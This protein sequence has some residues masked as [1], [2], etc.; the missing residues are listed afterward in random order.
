MRRLAA[1]LVLLVGALGA[2]GDEQPAEPAPPPEVQTR[3]KP[4]FCPKERFDRVRRPDGLYDVERVPRGTFDARDLL[5]L[6]E[7]AARKLAERNKCS[8]RVTT[9]NGERQATTRDLRVNR[10]NVVIERGYV[11]ALQSIG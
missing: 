7:S 2:C 8:V 5:G 10:I 1:P 9:R 11:T 3:T 6:R 4:V